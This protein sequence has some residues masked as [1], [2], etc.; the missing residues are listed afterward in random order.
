L[1]A[2]WAVKSWG[3]GQTTPLD[4]LAER[5]SI[6]RLLGQTTPENLQ[7]DTVSYTL[8]PHTRYPNLNTR[9]VLP[10]QVRGLYDSDDPSS[11]EQCLVSATVQEMPKKRRRKG[12]NYSVLGV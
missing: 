2:C 1:D 11:V 10:I 12:K 3:S 5:E 8:D 6:Y 9:S 4:V 7:R